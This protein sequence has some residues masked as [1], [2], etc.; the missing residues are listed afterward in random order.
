MRELLSDLTHVVEAG[1]QV[2]L[3]HFSKDKTTGNIDNGRMTNLLSFVVAKMGER[4]H[5]AIHPSELESFLRDIPWRIKEQM[6]RVGQENCVLLELS[7][8]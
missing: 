1:S 8:S 5:W 2:A 6:P 3:D 7:Y 4:F